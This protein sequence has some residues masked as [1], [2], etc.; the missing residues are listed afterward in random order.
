MNRR[1]FVL[2]SSLAS[3]I[4]CSRRASD[5]LELTIVAVSQE[6]DAYAAANLESAELSWM[7]ADGLAG[8]DPSAPAVGSLCVRPAMRS[9]TGR[10][11]SYAYELRSGVRWHDGKPLVAQD[12]ADCFKRLRTG[13]WGHQRPFDLVDRI[14]V[15]DARRF[16]VTLTQDDRRF[17]SAFFTP[18]GSPGLPLIRAGRIPIGTGPYRLSDRLPDAWTCERWDGSPRGTP[19]IRAMRLSYLADGRTQE[20]MLSSGETD[21]ALFVTGRY[22]F[23]RGIPFFRRRSGVAYAI[24]NAAG[25]LRDA[26]SRR[27]FAAAID[28]KE[29]VA[30]IYRG[31]TE[32]YD[33]VVASFVAGSDIGLAH[34]YDPAFAREAFRSNPPAHLE[35]AVI[36]GSSESIGILI[37]EHLARVGVKVSIRKYPAQVYLGP[38][39]PLRSGR[40]DVALFG[41]Y[42]SPDPDLNATWGCSARPPNGGN[43]SRLCDP[44]LDRLALSGDL[45]G[46]LEELRRQAT[47]VP[48]AASVQ[49][50]GLSKRMR[51]ARNARDLVPTVYACPEWS[52]A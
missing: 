12:V 9:L 18:I 31:M 51:G 50:V 26:Q 5:R 3:L 46:A 28:R 20:V 33:S 19:A 13:P 38:E 32:T 16:T 48:L 10:T 29:I 39:G 43:F 22:L 34:E 36:D 30:K 8:A 7:F 35:M 23:D 25:S 6:L 1:A 42:F 15:H 11:A 21:V 44:I 4:A 47:V 52:H 14:D 41:E 40:F 24:L 27:A 2:G 49:Y 37:Q 17:P 45:R